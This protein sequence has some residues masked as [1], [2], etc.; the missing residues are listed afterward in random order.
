[1]DDIVG[2]EKLGK[3]IKAEILQDDDARQVRRLFCF[4]VV[5]E[6]N[7]SCGPDSVYVGNR[8]FVE[9]CGYALAPT[10]TSS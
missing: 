1:M 7:V 5:S 3:R 10:L 9:M 2:A 6:M 4:R 8:R